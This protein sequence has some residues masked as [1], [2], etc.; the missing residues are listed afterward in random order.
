MRVIIFLLWILLGIFYWYSTQKCCVG[1]EVSQA[2]ETV[3]ASKAVDRPLTYNWANGE[4]ITGTRFNQYRDS[5][6]SS[7]KDNQILEIT[8]LYSKDEDKPA[9]FANLGLARAD[10]AREAMGL[11]KDDVK[12]NSRIVPTSRLSKVNKF[13]SVV[14]KNLV[15]STNIKEETV[16][17]ENNNVATKTTI[18]FPFNSTS[19]LDAGDVEDYLDQVASRVSASGE[20]VRLTG[21][22][23]NIGGDVQN[24]ALGQRRAEIVKNYLVRKGVSPNKVVTNSRGEAQPIA[25]NN[26]DAGR[27]KNRRTELQI[28]K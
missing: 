17:D 2:T 13:E 18:Y 14:F 3:V 11:G 26:T 22:T 15:N 20:K 12:L 19:K 16:V 6:I 28:I 23:D 8:G 25:T 10:G 27:Q 9:D 4:P 1:T 7:V 5:I 21:H 24:V